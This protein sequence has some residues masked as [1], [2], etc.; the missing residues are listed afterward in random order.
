MHR[1]Q[2]G[3]VCRRFVAGCFIRLG[4]LPRPKRGS[5]QAL[6]IAI[7]WGLIMPPAWAH[8]TLAGSGG[9]YSGFIHPLLEPAQLLLIVAIG[10]FCGQQRLKS[11]PRLLSAFML[12][13]IAG[14]ILSWVSLLPVP[15]SLLTPLILALAA[16]LGLLLTLALKTSAPIQIICILM[17]ALLLGL[18]SSHR[19]D[20]LSTQGLMYL[21]SAL[22]IPMFILYALALADFCNGRHWQRICIRILG[23]WI[24]ASCLMYLALLFR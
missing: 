24:A 17:A 15:A 7:G 11:K 2:Q 20:A 4:V 19:S 9:F 23:S 3:K 1:I 14:L 10:L 5:G 18:D 12:A 13:L 16:V 22:S 6:L 8:G 21:G